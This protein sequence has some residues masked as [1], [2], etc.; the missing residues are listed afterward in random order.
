MEPHKIKVLVIGG[1]LA[2]LVSSILLAKKGVEVHLIEKKAYPF[3]RVCG[4]YLSNEALDFLKKHELLPERNDLPQIKTFELSDTRGN[5]SRI[6]LDLGGFGISRYVLDEWMYQRALQEGVQIRTSTQ[7]NEIEYL[8]NE[9]Q[10]VLTLSDHSS[11]RAD[12]VIGAHGKRSKLDKMLKREFI[13]KRSPYLGVKY[14]IRTEFDRDCVALYNFQGG[15]CGLNAIEEDKFNLCYL[16]DRNQLRQYGSVEAMEKEVL[17]KNPILKKIWESSEFIF[18]KPEVITEINFEPKSPVEN[19]VLMAG[20]SAGLI[21]PLCGNGM[22]MAIHAGKLAAEA[23]IYGKSRLR[24]EEMYRTN[25]NDEFE[26][27]LWV[28]R[29]AQKL[30][31]SGKS[32]GFARKLIQ[33]IP[34]LAKIIIRNTHGKPF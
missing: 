29:Q 25:W 18:E 31:G 16:G 7:V 13:E 11:I 20:D 12:F 23:I 15:Y 8:K 1:G 2:G 6:P 17:H 30:F 22:A 26:K 5:I 34:P 27:R 32:S 33:T 24:V 19:H 9:D 21:T 28:G 3:H 10:F 4:E 14:H